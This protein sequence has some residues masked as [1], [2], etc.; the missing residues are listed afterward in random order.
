[1]NS[2]VKATLIGLYAVI[3]FFFAVYQHFWGKYN[4]KSFAFNLGQGIVWPAVMFPS[5]G[6]FIG[7]VLLLLIIAALTLRSR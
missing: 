3:G 5:V 2:H 4:Y 7:G 1:M 6:K